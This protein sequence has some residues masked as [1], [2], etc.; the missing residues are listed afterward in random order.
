[1]ENENYIKSM[2]LSAEQN[3][4]FDAIHNSPEPS[5]SP[6]APVLEIKQ[7]DKVKERHRRKRNREL[8]R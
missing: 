4:I 6:S 2:E 3:C 8:E 1:M 5:V 7:L